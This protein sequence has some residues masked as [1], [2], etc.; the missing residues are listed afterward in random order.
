V[1]G[2]ELHGREGDSEQWNELRKCTHAGRPFGKK[3]IGEGMVERFQRKW[4]LTVGKA[5]RIA[6]SG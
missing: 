6:Q 4:R 3:S 5:R 1:S 2:A